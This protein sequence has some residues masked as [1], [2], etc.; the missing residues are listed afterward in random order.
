MR[1]LGSA[2][3]N[4]RMFTMA[5]PFPPECLHRVKAIPAVWTR[6]A[7]QLKIRP[8][9]PPKREQGDACSY[10]ER[11]FSLQTRHSQHRRSHDDTGERVEP[12]VML[13]P[14]PGLVRIVH[15]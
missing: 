15:R 2:P 14:S 9:D 3:S 11:W 13:Q 4:Q 5:A 8:D 6:G 12:T 10:H 1:L 7:T